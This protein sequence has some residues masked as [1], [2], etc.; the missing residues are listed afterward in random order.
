MLN[1]QVLRENS[2]FVIDRLKVKNFDAKKI[3]AEIIELDNNRKTN[4]AERDNLQSTLNN[5]SKQIGICFKE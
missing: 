2:E 5:I 1:I 3:V 4:Q